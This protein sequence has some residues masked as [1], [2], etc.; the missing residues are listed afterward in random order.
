[1]EEES[2]VREQA[3]IF[4]K[5]KLTLYQQEINK[6]AGDICIRT[7][8]LLTQRGK[9]LEMARLHVDESGYQYKKKRSRSKHFGSTSEPAVRRPKFSKDLRME[10]IQ[11]IQE[12]LR[13]VDK[14]IDIKR[15]L[16]DQKVGE[17]RFGECD[18]IS[19][20]IDRLQGRRRTLSA[21]LRTFEKKERKAQWYESK[22]CAQGSSC[23]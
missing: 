9:L 6:A 2:A 13:T 14:R 22:K 7:P 21:E 17:H 8:A 4:K 20:G 16:L 18:R 1:M 15:K 12:E 11:E 5:E 3:R 10:R 23:I 19:E